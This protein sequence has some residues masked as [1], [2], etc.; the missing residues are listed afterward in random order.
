MKNIPRDIERVA[1]EMSM[2]FQG[3]ASVYL[4]SVDQ[5][6]RDVRTSKWQHTSEVMPTYT[7]QVDV[8]RRMDEAT[9]SIV[10]RGQH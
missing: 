4:F 3:M 10:A 5:G 2:R 8:N 7:R 9:E 6:M 1:E